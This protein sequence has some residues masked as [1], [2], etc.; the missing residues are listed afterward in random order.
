LGRVASLGFSQ[1]VTA[2]YLGV[3]VRSLSKADLRKS[4]VQRPLNAEADIEGYPKEAISHSQHE[5]PNS[6]HKK[7]SA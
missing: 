7:T 6:T 1:Y 5:T 4:Y 2:P 3:Y